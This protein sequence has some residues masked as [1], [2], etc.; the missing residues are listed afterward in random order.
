MFVC[1]LWTLLPRHVHVPGVRRH[2]RVRYAPDGER[3][4]L[5]DGRV[6]LLGLVQ[7]AVALQERRLQVD[8]GDQ[9]WGEKKKVKRFDF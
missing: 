8:A 4:A 9:L 6:A 3:E 5:Q 1:Q 7:E 2:H